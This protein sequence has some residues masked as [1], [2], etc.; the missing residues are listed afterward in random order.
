LVQPGVALWPGLGAVCGAIQFQQRAGL[1]LAL[2]MPGQHERHMAA[3]LYKLHP[4]SRITVC[5]TSLSSGNSAT[6][7]FNLALSCS[8]SRSSRTS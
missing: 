5:K 3:S 8:R 7:S 4:F 1:A 6:S 2:P